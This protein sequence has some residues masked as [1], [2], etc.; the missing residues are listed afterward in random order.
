LQQQRTVLDEMNGSDE[1]EEE[2]IR[3]YLS[4]IDLEEFKIREKTSPE[5]LS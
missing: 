5:N 1:F 2:L 4:V 3:K